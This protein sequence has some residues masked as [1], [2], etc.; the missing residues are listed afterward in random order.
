MP[1]ATPPGHDYCRG[2][3]PYRHHRT[4]QA[5]DPC[6]GAYQQGK[7]AG[8]RAVLEVM[9]HEVARAQASRRGIKDASAGGNR[10]HNKRFFALAAELGLRGPDSPDKVT[11][12][13]SCRLTGET[14]GS[15]AEMTAAIDR[16]RLPF[17]VDLTIPAGPGGGGGEGEDL[18][19]DGPDKPAKRG[20]R[21][22]AVECACRPQLRR[23]QL[24]PKQ[25]EDGPIV[26]GLCWL[27]IRAPRRRQ[28]WSVPAFMDTELGCQLTELPIP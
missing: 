1:A 3:E 12:W 28:G 15:Y 25:I 22:V 24:T 21:R 4:P 7:G 17:L 2:K 23:I 10:Y 27:R 6:P 9:L 26:C 20:G 19:E 16:A 18:G 13:S 11:G 5:R 8:G 14:I